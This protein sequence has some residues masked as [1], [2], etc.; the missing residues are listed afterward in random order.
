M[1]ALPEKAIEPA[2]ASSS[3]GHTE[4]PARPA[5]TGSAARVGELIAWDSTKPSVPTPQAHRMPP[6]RSTPAAR[7]GAGAHTIRG[8]E[9]QASS[10]APNAVPANPLGRGGHER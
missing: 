5:A 10:L 1:M 9:D 2:T 6:L 7:T 4:R 8:Y 3:P